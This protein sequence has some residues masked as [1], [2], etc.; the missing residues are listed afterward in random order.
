MSERRR[1]HCDAIL[2]YLAAGHR[3]TALEALNRFGCFRLGARIY[4][5]KHRGYPI[6]TCMITDE[7]TGKRFAQYWLVRRDT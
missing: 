2:S 5:L 1:T 4:D 3:L 6:G 7:D